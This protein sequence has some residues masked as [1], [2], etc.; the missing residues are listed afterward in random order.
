MA[1][2]LPDHGQ[3]GLEEGAEGRVRA[4]GSDLRMRKGWCELVLQH[5]FST[6]ADLIHRDSSMNGSSLRNGLNSD[7][8]VT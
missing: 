5:V 7:W 1:Q 3:E 8:E 4:R 6:S 2:G